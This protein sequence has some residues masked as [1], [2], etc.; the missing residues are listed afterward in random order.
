[1]IDEVIK[2]IP[3]LTREEALIIFSYTDEV[4]YRRLNAFLR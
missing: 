2:Q 4:I 1:M 3:N